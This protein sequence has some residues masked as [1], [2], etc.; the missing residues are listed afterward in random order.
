M[1]VWI[2]PVNWHL[3]IF[4]Q[5]G[6]LYHVHYCK[7]LSELTDMLKNSPNLLNFLQGAVLGFKAR[8]DLSLAYFVAL[9]QWIQWIQSELWIFIYG[10]DSPFNKK[11]PTDTSINYNSPKF[12]YDGSWW[13]SRWNGK[14]RID[15][16]ILQEWLLPFPFRWVLISLNIKR[17]W[18]FI[19]SAENRNLQFPRMKTSGR[20][21]FPFKI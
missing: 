13:P 4:K 15:C 14:K 17:A 12:T 19:F 1:K 16:H 9:M 10:I 2:F 8:V 6:G 7:S 18:I 11:C 5:E 21:V 3:Q 20:N